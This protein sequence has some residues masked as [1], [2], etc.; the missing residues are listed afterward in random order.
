MSDDKRQ[1]ALQNART[2]IASFLAPQPE[3]TLIIQEL[4][5]AINEPVIDIEQIKKQAF[6]EGYTKRSNEVLEEQTTSA[7]Q[8]QKWIAEAYKEGRTDR[9][10]ETAVELLDLPGIIKG[11]VQR[12]AGYAVE[13][14]NLGKQ[15]A[16]LEL[17]HSDEILNTDEGKKK[18]TNEGARKTAKEAALKT[19]E[20][21][22]ELLKQRIEREQKRREEEIELDYQR[23]LFKARLAIAGMQGVR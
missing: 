12:I 19:D 5:A 1:I 22:Q 13:I 6:Q 15:L 17:K 20:K 16:E 11:H 3:S 14:A 9:D 4:D 2:F 23:D 10:N 18:Y 21:Y 7:N 8:V